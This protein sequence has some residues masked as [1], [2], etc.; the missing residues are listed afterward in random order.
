MHKKAH[1]FITLLTNN[2][3]RLIYQWISLDATLVIIKATFSVVRNNLSEK[4][5]IEQI[6]GAGKNYSFKY[7]WLVIIAL[8]ISLILQFLPIKVKS[9]FWDREL[10]QWKLTFIFTKFRSKTVLQGLLSGLIQ[11]VTTESPLKMMKNDFYF[12]WKALFVLKIF[13]FLSCKKVAW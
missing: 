6:L 8:L 3:K 5:P 12:T 9:N 7:L 11:F 10:S 4:R 1:L 13:K 2:N